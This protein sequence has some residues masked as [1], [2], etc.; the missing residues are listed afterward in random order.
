MDHSPDE[1]KSG[2]NLPESVGA[3]D[4][5][6]RRTLVR[7]RGQ[8][9]LSRERRAKGV[10]AAGKVHLLQQMELALIEPHVVIFVEEYQPSVKRPMIGR[11]ERDPVPHVVRASGCPDWENVRRVHQTKLNTRY[12]AAVAVREKNL[13]TE[14][15]EAG[16]AT[17]FLN[18]ALARRRKNFDLACR[19]LLKVGNLV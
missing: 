12:S 11:G 14:T 4:K 16:K 18:D 15:G 19:G 6:L 9:D 5:V 7:I 13:L 8:E 1:A 10:G 3:T 17:H 2:H